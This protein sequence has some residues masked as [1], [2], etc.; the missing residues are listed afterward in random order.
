VPYVTGGRLIW[1]TPLEGLRIAAS[2]EE[3]RLKTI[4]FLPAMTIIHIRSDAVLWLASAEY[5]RYDVLVT[6]EY[7]RTYTKQSSDMPSLS[8]PRSATAEYG[9]LMASYRVTRWFQPGAYYALSF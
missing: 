5:S 3:F 4:A 9:Y 1:E 7:G 8:A 6:A 2:A